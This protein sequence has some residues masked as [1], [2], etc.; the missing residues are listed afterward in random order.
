[1]AVR[2]GQDAA[3]TELIDTVRAVLAATGWPVIA[4]T[5]ERITERHGRHEL[6]AMSDGQ[7][8]GE[9]L[10][11]L[12]ADVGDGEVDFVQAITKRVDAELR[13][14]PPDVVPQSTWP[15]AREITAALADGPTGRGWS[16]L[17]GALG[18]VHE[19]SRSRFRTELVAAAMA[20]W[21]G[22]PSTPAALREELAQAGLPA[23]LL[24]HVAVAMILEQPGIVTVSL[25][26]MVTAIGW[27]PR[28]TAEREELRERVWRWLNIFT[29]MRVIGERGATYQDAMTGRS[30]RLVSEDSLIAIVG[31][32]RASELARRT[33]LQV[34]LTAGRF[35]DRYR[36]NHRVLT[37]FGNVRELAV[38]PAGK[39]SGAWAQA[40]GLALGQHWRDHA[41]NSGSDGAAPAI[42][43]RALLDTI[44]AQPSV[45]E[46]LTGQHPKRAVTYYNQAIELLKQ[47][48][49]IGDYVEPPSPRG[50]QGWAEAWLDQLVEVRPG[51]AGLAAM[52]R[53][54]TSASRRAIGPR[55]SRRQI[56]AP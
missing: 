51:A 7:L 17:P 53:I 30:Q 4:Q 46:V 16:E 26:D 28:S 54:A 3:A 55:R 29:T 13:R 21:F 19:L 48:G 49:V 12:R 14:Q 41:A 24:L 40:I 32:D 18:L 38:I 5:I 25:D 56:P 11:V 8:Q 1:M 37:Y 42:S 15:E 23:A 33:P 31:I 2:P 43:R 39:P 20:A 35:P 27:A 34:S 50:R 9:I 22:A 36:G 44:R 10:N 47:R 6:L 45:Q 52:D